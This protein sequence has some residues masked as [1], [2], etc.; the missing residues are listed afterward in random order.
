MI[1]T[2]KYLLEDVKRIQALDIVPSILE[3]VCR[4]TG[5]GFSAV[6]RVTDDKWIACA[7]KDDISFGLKPGGELQL[8]TT[9]CNEIRAHHQPIIIDEVSTDPVFVNHHT[10]LMYGFQSYV[11]I[12]IFLKD[13]TFFGTLCAIDPRPFPLKQGNTVRM[14]E[15]YADLISFH[16]HAQDQ[17]IARNELLIRL[18]GKLEASME[19]INQYAHISQHTLQEPLKKLQIFSDMIVQ[20]SQDD[21]DM[22]KQLALEINALAKGVSVMITEAGSFSTVSQNRQGFER[23]NLNN[24]LNDSMAV[25]GS[26]ISEKGATVNNQLLPVVEGIPAQVGRLFINLLDN[27]LKFNRQGVPPVIKVYAQMATRE[28][29]QLAGL[30]AD[31]EYFKICIE[32][33]GMGIEEEHIPH[34]FNLFTKLHTGQKNTGIGMGLPQSRRIMRNHS[35][36]LHVQSQPGQGSVF[37]LWFPKVV[38]AESLEA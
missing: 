19:D 26:K 15:L 12:P 16:L 36:A 6:A 20:E 3:L 14:F 9:I 10:P 27:A 35:G 32:D 11:S 7:V 31:S 4:T 34:V 25:L 23:V 2:A 8:E 18:Q 38:F 24:V 28:E 29:T 22:T 21:N 13:G 1:D 37:T 33:N 17:A 30:E 5:M